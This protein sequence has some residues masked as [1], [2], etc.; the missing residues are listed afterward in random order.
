MKFE[1]AAHLTGNGSIKMMTIIIF[2]Y[3]MFILY[4]MYAVG[5]AQ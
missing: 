1:S 3:H 4:V 2:F 5:V